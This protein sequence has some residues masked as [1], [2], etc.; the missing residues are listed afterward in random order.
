LIALL[1][2]PVALNIPG[3]IRVAQAAPLEDCDAD[4]F[5]DATGAAVP[6][7]GYDETHGDT[8][9]GPGTADWWIA[10]NSSSGGGTGSSGGGGTS[11]SGGDTGGS[12]GSGGN[13]GTSGSTGG[14]GTK[15]STT[16]G[17][18]TTGAADGAATA[19]GAKPAVVAAP[20]ASAATAATSSAL[21]TL[22]T[23]TASTGSAESTGAIAGTTSGGTGT[24]AENSNLWESLTV[25]FTS[26]NTELVAGLILLAALV[27]AGGF[28]LGF[29]ALRR[30]TGV[31]AAGEATLHLVEESGA[32]TA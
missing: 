9:A 11:G 12:T 1:V 22:P 19:S 31:S 18:A 23:S 10:Q 32:G 8:P 28:A 7:P 3:A 13:S 25:G 26:Q 2:V 15:K 24:G 6:W 27:L 14:G 4:G 21:T 17:A 5:D 16:T 30:R 20:V 29:G